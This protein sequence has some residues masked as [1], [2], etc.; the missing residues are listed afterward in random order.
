M[1]DVEDC[2]NTISLNKKISDCINMP[3]QRIS[4]SGFFSFLN[5]IFLNFY[6]SFWGCE[7]DHFQESS[8]NIAYYCPKFYL[9]LHYDNNYKENKS[10]ILGFPLYCIWSLKRRGQ[11]NYSSREYFIHL[12]LH[13]F[14]YHIREIT[15]NIILK[16]IYGNS[17]FSTYFPFNF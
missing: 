3:G 4:T 6:H 10:C 9:I 16:K 13:F 5:R 14:F 15:W 17:T 2:I 7:K 12:C 1:K 8:I 11:K